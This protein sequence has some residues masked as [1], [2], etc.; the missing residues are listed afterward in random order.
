MSKEAEYA[1]NVL[2]FLNDYFMPC[3]IGI[4]NPKK[5]APII[6]YKVID[7]KEC[8]HWN[9]WKIIRLCNQDYR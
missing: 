3:F 7:A 2:G 5:D 9:K 6:K 4:G 8:I 1:K